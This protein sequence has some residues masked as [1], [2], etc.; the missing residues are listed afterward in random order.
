M[1]SIL[2]AIALVLA[3]LTACA[4]FDP[5]DYFDPATDPVFYVASADQNDFTIPFAFEADGDIVVA[6]TTDVATLAALND[7]PVTWSTR[8][9]TTHYTVT[10]EMGTSG[11]LSFTDTGCEAGS[12]DTAGCTAGTI[13]FIYRDDNPARTDDFGATISAAA[14]NL[15]FD[16]Q[17]VWVQENENILRRQGLKLPIT[18]YG[19]DV[20]LPQMTLLD[21]G[22]AVVVGST[23]LDFQY[24]AGDV[25][26]V[27]CP[28]GTCDGGANDGD[29]CVSDNECPGLCTSLAC[30]GGTGAGTVC[31]T[32]SDCVPTCDTG[33]NNCD[34][35]SVVGGAWVCSNGECPDS[36]TGDGTGGCL[37]C[38]QTGTCTGGDN[39]GG[40][41]VDD[42]DCAGVCTNL[43]CEVSGDACTTNAQC[44]GTCDL[45]DDV[46]F[47]G[48]GD[49]DACTDDA[50]CPDGG[51]CRPNDN[52]C[53]GGLEDTNP[54]TN[55][56]DCPGLCTALACVGGP[57]DG[58]VCAANADCVTACVDPDDLCDG[59][60]LGD[61]GG[62]WVAQLCDGGDNH[63]DLC[64]TNTD[65]TGGTCGSDPCGSCGGLCTANADCGDSCACDVDNI[66]LGGT[67]DGDG[68]T[69]DTDCPG[70]CTALVCVENGGTCATNSDCGGVC[71]PEFDD[72]TC[73]GGTNDGDPCTDD[74]DCPAGGTC[75][76]E[77]AV[78]VR[79]IPPVT[80]S[81]ITL[82]AGNSGGF[83]ECSRATIGP[84]GFLRDI[85][86]LSFSQV[87]E[88][89]TAE[90]V[91][92]QPY[93]AA[94]AAAR[95]A[96][97]A[98]YELPDESPSYLQDTNNWPSDTQFGWM[99]VDKDHGDVTGRTKTRWAVS[100]YPIH[101][102]SPGVNTDAQ[103][104]LRTY[105]TEPVVC[106]HDFA[107]SEVW[108]ATAFTGST[109]YTLQDNGSTIG[110]ITC[111]T[112]AAPN[113]CVIDVTAGEGACVDDAGACTTNGDCTPST[114][115]FVTNFAVGD[116]LDIDG[117]AT[118]DATGGNLSIT[119]K[120]FR[121]ANDEVLP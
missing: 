76:L 79:M 30:V 98:W 99:S 2:A 23:A 7:G 101:V 119:L 85:S 65:C 75:E 24:S 90:R 11:T 93:P 60:T 37:D 62:G 88:T 56:V 53:F 48:P 81:C 38:G 120:C 86:A 97:G 51:T 52:V 28:G 9:L 31:A 39:A 73:Q 29:A 114:C 34:Y 82:A 100:T 80:D 4:D 71:A 110:T 19:K 25:S 17:T 92:L 78:G 121:S 118:A 15:N 12:D 33:F 16:R 87:V 54:C 102:F 1:K 49:G 46:C 69:N 111:D 36:C 64:S 66:C 67:N 112:D 109:V 74:A 8:T 14:L 3:P 103:L 113:E 61:S 105:F 57:D 104:I 91:T 6:T 5:S 22:S 21:T 43:F 77:D 55:D 10:G 58:T 26:C 117:P 83:I 45:D 95:L 59:C 44:S 13:V 70:V 20:T 106:L 96:A 27:E 115:E 107:G 35:I 32:N 84:T 63:G 41:C 94:T 108:N 68:C 18:D 116:Y 89:S 72:E 50:D 42:T 40:A 47:G